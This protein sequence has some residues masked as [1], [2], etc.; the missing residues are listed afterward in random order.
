MT[1]RA[2]LAGLAIVALAACAARAPIDDAPVALLCAGAMKAPI[3][4][5][6]ARSDGS[7]TRVVADYATAGV[8]RE[9]VA[10]GERPDVV[11]APAEL[12]DALAADG[13]VDP[14]TRRPLGETEIGV[15]VRAGAPIPDIGTPDALRA[16]L[17]GARRIVLVDPDNG[18]SGRLMLGVLDALGV[19]DAVRGKLLMVA[20]G[21]VV[22]AVARGEAD[23]GFQ[24]ISEIL[25]VAGVR[26]VGPLPAPLRR[27][28]R[29]DAVVT[30]GAAHP[31]QAAAWIRG[32]DRDDVR[33]TI[34]ASGFT[35]R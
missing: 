23:V 33:A 11:V 12:V 6:L 5:V 34:A 19:R 3:A 35:P 15:A 8:I 29:Y 14:A 7:S 22:E 13:R 32:L 4:T 24:Q 30:T 25:P 27:A 1:L 9:R 28:T 20:G 16:T 17:V 26:L 21:N 31:A 2:T 10:R 18:T